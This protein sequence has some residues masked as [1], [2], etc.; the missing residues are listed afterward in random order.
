MQMLQGWQKPKSLVTAVLARRIT[1]GVV[2]ACLVAV[3]VCMV[4]A[5]YQRPTCTIAVL[6]PKDVVRPVASFL[7]ATASSLSPSKPL[8]SE[9]MACD[10]AHL[11]CQANGRA[12][13]Q[14]ARLGMPQALITLEGP[15]LKHQSQTLL[16]TARRNWN[17]QSTLVLYV[18]GVLSIENKQPAIC[19]REHEATHGGGELLLLPLVE[20][21]QQIE[22][23]QIL[24]CLDLVPPN[25]AAPSVLAAPLI[26]DQLNE[27][28][29]QALSKHSRRAQLAV[30]VHL[31]SVAQVIERDRNASPLASALARALRESADDGYFDLNR[32]KEVL[33]KVST[34]T[35]ATSE[36][37]WLTSLNW[38][39]SSQAIRLPQ[40]RH[41]TPSSV[42]PADP[43]I[44]DPSTTGKPARALSL[45][46]DIDDQLSD[47]ELWKLGDLAL[48]ALTRVEPVTSA[49]RPPVWLPMPQE[50]SY[51]Q[52]HPFLV[53]SIEHRWQ[54]LT[55]ARHLSS[56]PLDAN[57]VRNVVRAMV[58]LA[59]GGPQPIQQVAGSLTTAHPPVDLRFDPSQSLL[60]NAILVGLDGA[61]REVASQSL[62]TLC[63]LTRA[64]DHSPGQV[65][66]LKEI[67]QLVTGELS[68]PLEVT[69]CRGLCNLRLPWPTLQRL[70][71]LE[72]LT[73][74]SRVDLFGDAPQAVALLDEA[75]ALSSQIRA[76]IS[77][78]VDRQLNAQS[79]LKPNS[80]PDF[81]Q[82][83][84]TGVVSDI[85]LDAMTERAQKLTRAAIDHMTAQSLASWSRRDA[86]RHTLLH[87]AWTRQSGTVHHA[88]QQALAE[89]SRSWQQLVGNREPRQQ[90]STPS[91]PTSE[92]ISLILK[93]QRLLQDGNAPRRQQIEALLQLNRRVIAVAET[94]SASLP[95][96]RTAA[97][98][99]RDSAVEAAALRFFLHLVSSDRT[100]PAYAWVEERLQ[101]IVEQNIEQAHRQLQD[102]TSL[103]QSEVE[104][105]L[106]V[107]DRLASSLRDQGIPI[108]N[109]RSAAS[110]LSI[111]VPAHLDLQGKSSC[112]VPCTIRYEPSLNS[113]P[114][115]TTKYDEQALSVQLRERGSP[116]GL[117]ASQRHLLVSVQRI[118]D[119]PVKEP[120]VLLVSHGRTQ[121][122][123]VIQLQTARPPLVDVLLNSQA[124]ITAIEP[125]DAID[126]K[127]L[128]HPNRAQALVFQLRSRQDETL[129][130]QTQVWAAMAPLDDVPS[131]SITFEAADDWL[132]SHSGLVPLGQ[133]EDLR[134]DPETTQRVVLKPLPTIPELKQTPLGLH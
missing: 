100:L 114:Q 37:L 71:R 65:E 26:V 79:K 82:L 7:T 13:E 41:T 48:A 127:C 132:K 54:L 12:V 11:L 53:A 81:A 25:H 98:T 64:I 51:C 31:N 118:A 128:L 124:G 133:S 129:N 61:Q 97:T 6:A 22:C 109:Q 87:H 34:D 106:T 84:A 43:A 27:L 35:P 77:L 14:S 131:G 36:P 96:P 115:V 126:D 49:Q 123:A 117:D 111:Q 55:A 4:R 73:L 125:G 68:P 94:L 16:S 8:A 90:S 32:I 130:G 72:L 75:D 91:E 42:D 89:F 103:Q 99:T 86:L 107:W 85:E 93:S 92:V 39:T 110:T 56:S 40:A 17:A 95:S 101:Q 102:A 59:K 38:P 105:W 57:D 88:T 20:N 112:L 18:S 83:E 113:L 24:L 47:A 44:A 10:L 80:S 21:L 121:R 45:D 50:L 116:D 134:L 78:T 5:P 122:R 66:F 19:D 52:R 33:S 63:R 119:R 74:R 60:V 104:Q 69:R 120:I 46:M 67:D 1:A 9:A 15:Q 108:A 70:L 30:V 62:K 76:K 23:G 3:F 28:L 2:L 58:D 29:E